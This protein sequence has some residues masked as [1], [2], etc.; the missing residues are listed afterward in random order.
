MSNLQHH[1]DGNA[2][3]AFDDEPGV[4]DLD[5][6]LD[7]DPNPLDAETQRRSLREDEVTRDLDESGEFAPV[8][9]A[10]PVTD[11]R[12][13]GHERG[14]GFWEI[15][16]VVVG[17]I[18]AHVGVAQAIP[19][20]GNEPP[21]RLPSKVEIAFVRP[22]PV[23]IPPQV[24]KPKPPAPRPRVQKVAAAEPP[25]PPPEPT[26]E[27]APVEE[28]APAPPGPEGTVV[29]A[30]TNGVYGT[31][32]G[33]GTAPVA[34]PAPPPVVSAHEGANYLQNPRPAYPAIA[35]SRGW[36]GKVLLRVQVGPDGRPRSIAVSQ[37]SGRQLL[38]DA[39]VAAVR[40]W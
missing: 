3:R 21:P 7:N 31:G 15:A 37:G 11:V 19:R 34:P 17:S 13:H 10:Q 32:T 24:E 12:V 36:Q 20:A 22:T 23:V 8:A 38:D 1:T 26:E 6:D 35:L 25:P 9:A 4:N 14:I 5:N 18:G 28:E 29:A 16:L 40:G 39:A 30:A 2:A 27:P 33:Q